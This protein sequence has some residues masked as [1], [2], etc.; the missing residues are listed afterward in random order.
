[1][2]SSFFSK[3][4]KPGH[5]PLKQEKHPTHTEIRKDVSIPR[6]PNFT[7][8]VHL[9]RTVVKPRRQD[10]A[11]PK[12]SP[13]P[14][15]QNPRKRPGPA[16]QRLE[17]DSDE[18]GSDK[19]LLDANKRARRSSEVEP[20][21]KRHIRSRKAFS[22]EDGGKFSM[23]HA[24]EIATL[25]KPTE[26]KPAFPKDPEATE[27]HLQYPSA[28]QREK[29]ELVVPVS[30]DDFKT[31][32]DIREVMEI[33]I[34]NYLP[35]ETGATLVNDSTGL[36][37]RI[38]RAVD[39]LAGNEYTDHIQEWNNTLVEYRED[40]TITK[41]ID[42]WKSIDL[43][44][45]ER[46]L[47]QTYSRTVS[48]RVDDLKKYANGTDN[49][50]GELLPRF[51]SKILK[52]DT[53]MKTDQ[54]FVDLGSGVGNCVLQAALEVGCESWGCEMMKDACDLADL[55][56]KE[57]KARCRLWG[58][59]MGDIHLE[60]GDFLK[61]ENIRKVLQRADVVLVNN[62]AFT[63]SLNEDLTN[64]FLD[65]KEGA[66]VISLKS[67]VPM[68]QK[69]QAK[70]SGAIYNILDV[71]EKWYYSAC[72]SWTDAAGTYYVSTKDSSRVKAVDR[73]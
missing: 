25:S 1:M 17:S 7:H 29:Y 15:T 69:N 65:L 47:T 48:P 49:V 34:S 54:V 71:T 22:D 4:Q 39:R 31:L 32:E 62:Q 30:N 50:Y 46:I 23:I 13:K 36:L 20:D 24:S 3:L 16:Q 6:R 14:R 21:L 35:V 68:G 60:R 57:F 56:K 53:L 55:Q 11:K 59:S 70:N 44:L 51:V 66:K 37:R 40:G 19:D 10:T 52:K 12:T 42:G 43:K 5:K 33:I 27:V 8:P 9:K 67:F 26:Y 38:K 64:L 73:E 45:L 18:A 61:N 63:P 2:P 58:L 28:S 41:A 72:V